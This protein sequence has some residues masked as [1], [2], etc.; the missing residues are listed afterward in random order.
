MLNDEVRLVGVPDGTTLNHWNAMRMHVYRACGMTIED[1]SGSV[2][3]AEV[4]E[5]AAFSGLFNDSRDLEVPSGGAI[6]FPLNSVASRKPPRCFE[7]P[8]RPSHLRLWER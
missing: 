7:C 5:S 1:F 3:P 2:L 4:V 8:Y 6:R